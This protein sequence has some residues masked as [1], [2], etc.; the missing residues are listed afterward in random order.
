MVCHMYGA[1]PLFAMPCIC[2]LE[3]E[4][5]CQVLLNFS[6]LLLKLHCCYWNFH[7]ILAKILKFALISQWFPHKN[8]EICVKLCKNTEIIAICYWSE[9]LEVGSPVWET[10]QL[11]LNQNTWVKI[12]VFS[13]YIGNC[14]LQNVDY[15][16]LLTIIPFNWYFCS[17]I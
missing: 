5:G 13:E 15:K 16:T 14:G 2:H 7:E 3:Y 8:T 10:N 12:F 11:H 4:Q 9:F 17:V 1:M 6:I